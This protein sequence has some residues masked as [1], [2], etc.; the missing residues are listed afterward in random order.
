[1]LSSRR[2]AVHPG[3]P[4]TLSSVCILTRPDRA[5]RK[6]SAL[7]HRR[8]RGPFASLSAMAVRW[9][10]VGPHAHCQGAV[11]EVDSRH[12]PEIRRVRVAG[13]GQ[14]LLHQQVAGGGREE[15]HR[16]TGRTSQERGFP[17][18]TAADSPRLTEWSSMRG[19][20]WTENAAAHSLFQAGSRRAGYCA[21][22][23]AAFHRFSN[24]RPANDAERGQPA[25]RNAARPFIQRLRRSS[26]KSHSRLSGGQTRAGRCRGFAERSQSTSRCR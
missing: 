13:M 18:G 16:R 22:Q 23:T 2:K 19:M 14:R 7:R 20:R 6:G 3:L 1:M 17:A 12:I 26:Q 5:D 4:A 10:R 25:E 21:F 8:R 9:L 11:L 24:R 15:R